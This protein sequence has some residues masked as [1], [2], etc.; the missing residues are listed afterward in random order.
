[1]SC[2]G[3]K[4][5]RNGSLQFTGTTT[6]WREKKYNS[7]CHTTISKIRSPSENL[8]PAIYVKK[9]HWRWVLLRTRLKIGQDNACVAL[10]RRQRSKLMVPE[11]FSSGAWK[12]RPSVRTNTRFHMANSKSTHDF[13]L[14]K[15]FHENIFKGA[16]KDLKIIWREKKTLQ[17]NSSLPKKTLF[18]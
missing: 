17:R 18:S 12:K 8:I 11:S 5:K 7:V 1:M 14:C 6:S 13:C 10:Q 9:W 4:I 15:V 16:Q 3:K 2:F